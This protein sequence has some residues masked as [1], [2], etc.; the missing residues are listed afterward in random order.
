MRC[1]Q[2]IRDYE[3]ADELAGI[4]GSMR[5]L[6][7]SAGLETEEIKACF[8][9]M[10]G[11][12]MS[13]VKALFIPTAAIDADAI[14]VLPKCMNDLLKCGISKK[15]IDVYDLHAGMEFE[16]LKQYD[17]VYLCGGNTQYLLER[18]NAT[19]FHESFMAYINDNGLVIGVSAG[20]LIFS[21]NLEKNLGLIDTKLDV[22]CVMGE[23]RGKVT[24][25]LKENV[26]LTNTCAL[27]IRDFPDDMEIIGE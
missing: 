13:F 24:Y 12:D 9:D 27:V 19:R 25:P 14:G 26:K 16:K 4:G 5:V 1:V 2:G 22:H 8:V 6:L 17:V 18:I 20:S 10:A 23:K 11:K 21:N 3:R 7:T 15:N